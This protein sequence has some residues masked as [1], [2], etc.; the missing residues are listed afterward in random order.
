[1][2]LTAGENLIKQ[3]PVSETIQYSIIADDK[4]TWAPKS[5]SDKSNAS[6]IWSYENI[7]DV[8]GLLNPQPTDRILDIG[9][10]SG[11]LTFTLSGA[12]VIGTDASAVMISQAKAANSNDKVKY[13]VVDGLDLINGLERVGVTG[14]FDKVFSNAALHW[15]KSDPG[16]VVR[17]ARRL[18]KPGGVFAAEFGGYLNLGEVAFNWITIVADLLPLLFSPFPA[19]PVGVLS[20]THAALRRRGIDPVPIDPFYFPSPKQHAEV[21]TAN[22]FIVDSIGMFLI[23]LTWQSPSVWSPSAVNVPRTIPLKNGLRSWLITF[24]SAYTAVLPTQEEKN[25][26]WDEVVEECKRDMYCEG[27]GWT[28]MYMRLRFKAIAK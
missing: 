17:D 28:I 18:L 12:E 26:L 7:K 6:Y 11:E 14:T 10:G 3:V 1:M 13:Y 16:K 22:G 5:P 23:S 27:E 9:C 19:W 4:L 25:A 20:A 2:R 21:L 24:G 8:V 15:M